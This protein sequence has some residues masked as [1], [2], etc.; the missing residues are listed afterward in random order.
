MCYWLKPHAKFII[1]PLMPSPTSH[2][3]LEHSKLY[4]LCDTILSPLEFTGITLQ[5][6]LNYR[7]C[8]FAGWYRLVGISLLMSHVIALATFVPAVVGRIEARSG[9][10]V[11]QGMVFVLYIVVGWQALTLS[12]VPQAV[13]DENEE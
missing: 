1:P 7:S 13:G 9:W 8:T 6:L 11:E 5:L 2:D 12:S 4:N 10:S 3:V